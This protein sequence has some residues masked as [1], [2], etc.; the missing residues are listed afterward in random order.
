[1]GDSGFGTGSRQGIVAVRAGTPVPAD[2][3]RNKSKRLVI[4]DGI[5]Y[6]NPALP[7]SIHFLRYS[8]AS[9]VSS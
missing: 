4:H 3:R 6:T 5:D 1:M 7:C 9:G 2:I 8:T